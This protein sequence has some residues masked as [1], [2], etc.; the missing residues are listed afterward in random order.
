MTK[1]HLDSTLLKK[2]KKTSNS[3]ASHL[4][5]KDSIELSMYIQDLYARE[6]SRW[7][8]KKIHLKTMSQKNT[9]GY[10]NMELTRS[11]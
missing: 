4:K 8:I 2:K 9:L 10:Q 6:A 11:K 3:K 1:I 7:T 5:Q